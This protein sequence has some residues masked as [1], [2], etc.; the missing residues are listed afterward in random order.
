MHDLIDFPKGSFWLLWGTQISLSSKVGP[1]LS[2][3]HSS[4]AT[5]VGPLTEQAVNK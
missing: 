2:C 3:V 5:S 4:L 1:L